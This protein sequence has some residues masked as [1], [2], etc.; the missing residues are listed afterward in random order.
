MYWNE[1]GNAFWQDA[2][3]YWT[4]EIVYTLEWAF[5]CNPTDFSLCFDG[6]TTLASVQGQPPGKYQ[7]P[8]AVLLGPICKSMGD[9]NAY[10]LSYLD[11]IKSF[12]KSTAAGLGYNILVQG[13]QGFN[14][15]YSI[16]DIAHITNPSNFLNRKEFPVD[17]PV[18]HNPNDVAQGKDAV[19]EAAL[20]WIDNLVYGYNVVTDN[21]YYISGN[22][23]A[24]I[25]AMVENPNSNNISAK[26]F[27]ENLENTF[28][29]SIELAPTESSEIWQGDWLVPNA[30][31]IYKLKI[32]AIDNTLGESFSFSNVQRISTAGPVVIDL[33]DVTYL[34]V[35]KIYQVKPYIK[36]KGQSFT[37]ENLTISLLTFDS[38]VSIISG[39]LSITSIAPGRS[40]VPSGSF[41][42]RV[43]S[44]FTGTFQF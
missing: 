4:N 42:V 10:R 13:Y 18:W 38:T 32:K 30:E 23:T 3:R 26:V 44:N 34:P 40:L 11:N 19:V 29:D 35:P 41:T 7:R 37:I 24:N 43:D 9:I 39:T 1:G 21:Q 12:G 31:D 25:S 15:R 5:R 6:D 22:D 16:A 8:I 2:F 17:F 36:N 20:E 33:L 14:F 28:I 27:I